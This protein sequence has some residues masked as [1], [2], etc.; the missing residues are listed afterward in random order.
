[1]A[2]TIDDL[3]DLFERY[4]QNNGQNN[5]GGNAGVFSGGG[6]SRGFSSKKMDADELDKTF[7]KYRDKL[8]KVG[9]KKVEYN[10]SET[11][12]YLKLQ[13]EIEEREERISELYDEINDSLDRRNELLEK[14]EDMR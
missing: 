14:R 3:Y 5:G 6:N 9:Q 2:K 4:L 1:M 13:K 12:K 10:L 8:D 7:E 11:E